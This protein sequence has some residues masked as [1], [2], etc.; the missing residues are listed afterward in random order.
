MSQKISVTEKTIEYLK[1]KILQPETKI[2][3]KLATEHEVCETLNVGRGSVRE[4]FRNLEAQGYIEIKPG[5]GAFVVRKTGDDEVSLSEWFDRN[6]LKLNDY[7][8]VR[9]IVEPKAA[10]LAAE[11]STEAELEHLTAIHTQFVAE[12][13]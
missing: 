13:H 2:G 6:R 5:R 7:T 12:V 10:R 4:A 3:D 11:R 1:E 8:E 9:E